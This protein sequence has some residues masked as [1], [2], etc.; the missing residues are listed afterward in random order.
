MRVFVDRRSPAGNTSGSGCVTGGIGA[1]RVQVT[2]LAALGRP[3]QA[4]LEARPGRRSI[5]GGI[6]R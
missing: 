3:G 1:G 5:A 2:G 4:A 6:T